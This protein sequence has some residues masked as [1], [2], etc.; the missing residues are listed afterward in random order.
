MNL[1]QMKA[2][3]AAKQKRAE[4]LKGLITGEKD[5]AKLEAL[6]KEAETNANERAEL[7]AEINVELRKQAESAISK[8]PMPVGKVADEHKNEVVPTYSRRGAISLLLGCA[9]R[10]HSITDVQARALGTA[11]T[12]TADTFVAATESVNGVNNGG[13]FIKTS[14]LL[15]LLAEEKKLT[16]I[17]D[18]IIFKNVPGLLVFPYRESRG[19]A[20]AKAEGKG[21]GETPE[22]WA[23]LSLVAGYLQIKVPVTDELLDLTD[24]D[25]GTYLADQI[26]QDLS[27]DWSADFIY[28]TGA[29]NHIAGITLGLTAKT[30]AAG[31]EL[32]TL[33]ASIKTLK[34]KYRNGA[35]IYCAQDL[36]DTCRFA[37]NSDGDY[38]VPFFSNDSIT[39]AG[40]LPIKV[41]ETL[42]DGEFII[43]NVGRFYIVNLLNSIHLETKRDV[44]EGITTYIAKQHAA[45]KAV[46]NAF[47][48]GKAA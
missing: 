37:K 14:I 26:V 45:G 17:M 3:L 42:K 36:F 12:T 40:A 23:Q 24:F 47:V 10:K 33:E 25:F 48:Y 29:N 19:S 1:E 43:G 28:G 7:T 22:K 21:T 6:A 18:A 38:I 11:L 20:E 4:E 9:A 30:Y 15:D 27:E 8:N 41:D 5:T 13:I 35:V 2:A 32:A 31:K 44:D 39:V 34:G 16:P 46:P